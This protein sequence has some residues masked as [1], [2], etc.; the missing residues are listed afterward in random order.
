MGIV[1]KR[2]PSLWV[3]DYEHYLSKHQL[4]GVTVYSSLM[5][6]RAPSENQRL[7]KLNRTLNKNHRSAVFPT[8]REAR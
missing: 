5:V 2:V 3:R 6:D 7:Y 1:E 4:P 8:S